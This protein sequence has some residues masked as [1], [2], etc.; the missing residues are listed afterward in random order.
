[1]LVIL[2]GG[3]NW[4]MAFLFVLAAS[5]EG[6]SR[7][8]ARGRERTRAPLALQPAPPAHASPHP[9]WHGVPANP[10]AVRPLSRSATQPLQCLCLSCLGEQ[11][12]K[13]P[14]PPHN[15]DVELGVAVGSGEGSWPLVCCVLSLP[16]AA[17]GTAD[18]LPAPECAVETQ[19]GSRVAVVA[20]RCYRHSR[21]PVRLGGGW[22]RL[23]HWL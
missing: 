17:P 11:L 21:L 1:M 6:S 12:L 4:A 7:A 2:G 19:S 16:T 14:F 9:C 5:G 23:G 18:A 13:L 22:Q 15:K 20:G 8:R 10:W 3:T